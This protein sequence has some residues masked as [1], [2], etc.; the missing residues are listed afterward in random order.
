M[1]KSLPTPWL[2]DLAIALMDSSQEGG[3]VSKKF[4]ASSNKNRMVQVIAVDKDMKTLTLNDKRHTIVAM[5]TA[6]CY[7]DILKKHDSLE[8]IENSIVTLK[9]KGY[10]MS[11]AHQCAGTRDLNKFRESGKVISLPFALQ[12][13]SLSLSGA[14][15]T[16]VFT[17]KLGVM[18]K[19]MNHDKDVMCRLEKLS[20]P[21]LT[22][23]LG[24]LQFPLEGYLPD[25][26]GNFDLA[27]R[28]SNENPL[29]PV[30][31]SISLIQQYQLDNMQQFD[32]VRNVELILQA[33]AMLLEKDAEVEKLGEAQGSPRRYSPR[34][35][36]SAMSGGRSGGERELTAEERN[37]LLRG[38]VGAVAEG[39]VTNS[40]SSPILGRKTQ[41]PVEAVQSGGVLY[42]RS[43]A[44]RC[45]R[46]PG[47]R[48][49]Q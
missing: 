45:T 28:Y 5:L 44:I 9:E 48:Q 11:T 21:E 20:Y 25:A 22:K 17:E 10:H 40:S 33:D 27:P 4:R 16:E 42:V 41:T 19:A 36:L 32:R 43:R 39:I 14:S 26:D 7:D 38:V 29:L 1:S 35:S 30:H 37:T 24:Q 12:V 49:W 3:K 46:A 6:G 47:Y 34:S 31:T 18:P 13:S 15:D 2:K 8:D 23:K